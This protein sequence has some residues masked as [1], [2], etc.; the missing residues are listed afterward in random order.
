[1]P[2]DMTPRPNLP[3]G[4]DPVVAVEFPNVLRR[5][6]NRGDGQ[7]WVPARKPDAPTGWRNRPTDKPE[8]RQR[9][10]RLKELVGALGFASPTDYFASD[11]FRHVVARAL[12]KLGA[13]CVR[14]GDLATQVHF[15]RRTPANLSG[16]SLRNVHPVCKECRRASGLRPD[17][18]KTTLDEANAF[19]LR[20]KP[21]GGP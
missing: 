10:P 15:A 4:P 19:L 16:R 20:R 21:G 5:L 17:G 3:G 8:P 9:K 6:K 13:T 14:C 7:V 11:L 18:K 1:M 2:F 12:E